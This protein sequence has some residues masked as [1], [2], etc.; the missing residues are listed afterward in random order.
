MWRI[1]FCVIKTVRHSAT[2]LPSLDYL[3]SKSYDCTE[4]C[5]RLFLFIRID[6]PLWVIYLALIVVLN[7]FL[8]IILNLL[9]SLGVHF[10]KSVNVWNVMYVFKIYGVVYH[11]W[12]LRIYL[13]LLFL[14][15]CTCLNLHVSWI[16]GSGSYSV[17]RLKKR[18]LMLMLTWF[19][20]YVEDCKTL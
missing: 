15:K 13:P 6:L 18:Q 5:G 3:T 4:V 1:I 16:A 10:Q 20:G 2:E 12:P 19:E 17:I 8:S 14:L 9:L 7:Q 11:G